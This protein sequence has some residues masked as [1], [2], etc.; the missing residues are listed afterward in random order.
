MKRTI[1]A[2]VCVLLAV[3]ALR[4]QASTQAPAQTT[5]PAKPGAAS[6]EG[7]PIANKTV[8]TLCGDCHSTDAKGRMSRISTRRTTPEGWQE[9]IRRMATLH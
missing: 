1:G 6:D 9:T 7:I 4:T 5:P 8:T 3:A 2:W